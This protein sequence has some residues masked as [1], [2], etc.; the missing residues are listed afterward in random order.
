MRKIAAKPC[1]GDKASLP[2]DFFRKFL[3]QYSGVFSA[4]EQGA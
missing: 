4:R 2:V 1:P 3:A